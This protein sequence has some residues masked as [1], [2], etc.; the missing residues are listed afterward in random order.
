MAQLVKLQD[1]I[2]RY[3]LDATLYINRFLRLKKR[4]WQQFKEAIPI[5]DD[6]EMNVARKQYLDKLFSTQLRWASS[7]ITHKS[8]LD[9]KYER[10]ETLKQLIK[11]LPDTHL[12]FYE[13]VFRLENA[14]V[15][16]AI[17]IVAPTTIYCIAALDSMSNDIYQAVDDRYWQRLRGNDE[18]RVISPMLALSRTTSVI[19]RVLSTT[20]NMM[21]M[22][23]KEIVLCPNGY[24]EHFHSTSADCVDIRNYREWYTKM[25]GN[26]SPMKHQ[27]LKTVQSLFDH[28]QTTA[29]VRT[30]GS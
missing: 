30:I 6:D 22:P 3:E 11:Q 25:S 20:L 12:V 27:Q 17:I 16:L 19:R 8:I 18:T 10:D 5:N 1:H 29:V 13:P 2:S 15:E 7:T 9:E 4:R 14:D 24:I 23:L 21:P 28:C 26:R